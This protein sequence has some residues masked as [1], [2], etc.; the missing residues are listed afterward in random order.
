MHL[1]R[2]HG[3][4]EH[5]IQGTSITSTDT[6]K[7][8]GVLID[9]DLKFHAHAEAIISKDNHTLAIIRKTFQFTDKNMSIILYKTLVRPIIEYGNSVWG[10]YY[11]L[12]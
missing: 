11:I 2:S 10:P 9:S 5:N 12:D 4:G 3:Y 7:D 8:L 1:G 6:V